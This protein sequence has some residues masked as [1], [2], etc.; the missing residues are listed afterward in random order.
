MSS[1][2]I[3]RL[4][5]SPFVRATPSAGR[6][7]EEGRG[8]FV[9]CLFALPLPAHPFIHWHLSLLLWDSNIYRRLAGT[10]SLAGPSS[11]Q[12]LGLSISQL[13]INCGTIACKS[14]QVHIHICI[15]YTYM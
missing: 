12:I 5:G 3:L 6:T 7:Q 13:A 11:Y 9:L 10:F 15:L 2:E 4:E 8:V 1:I 14:F